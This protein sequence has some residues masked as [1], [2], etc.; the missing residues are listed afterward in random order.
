MCILSYNFISLYELNLLEKTY[1]RKLSVGI[2]GKF[3]EPIYGIGD[4]LPPSV[5]GLCTA[6]FNVDFLMF[7]RLNGF[8]FYLTLF[9]KS[10]NFPIFFFLSLGDLINDLAIFLG[11]NFYFII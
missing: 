3:L 6:F 11:L 9:M 8:F 1:L 4:I 2:V 5:D 7:F 10:P